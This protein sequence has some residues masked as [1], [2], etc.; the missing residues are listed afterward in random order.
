MG[1]VAGWLKIHPDGLQIGK[2]LKECLWEERDMKTKAE[3]P[4]T[5]D[6]YIA[7][8]PED[9]Q[10]I[11]TKIRK[12]IHAAAPKASEAI[13]YQMPTFKLEGNLIHF[14]AFSKH[15]G[16]YP[17]PSAMGKFKKELSKYASG[18]GSV[19]LPLHEPIPYGL[20]KQMVVFRVHEN[21]QKAKQKNL[22]IR[23]KKGQ[24]N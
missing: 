20:I 4:K 23:R 24:A 9:I 17:T 15:I 7:T 3:L 16:I 2:V 1:D 19:Q 5:M 13:S 11:L 8:F 18:K 12:T 14:A 6:A 22:S 10:E 21:Q